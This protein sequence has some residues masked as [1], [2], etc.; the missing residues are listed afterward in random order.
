[1]RR[2]GLLLALVPA[3]ILLAPDMALA[4]RYSDN[5]LNLVTVILAAVGIAIFFIYCFYEHGFH[6]GRKKTEVRY[7]SILRSEKEKIRYEHSMEKQMIIAEMDGQRKALA[8]EM[9]RQHK[10]LAEKEASLEERRDT[11]EKIVAEKE[12]G[13]PWLAGKLAEFYTA[14]DEATAEWSETKNIPAYKAADE[15]K[16][17]ASE[18]RALLKKLRVY[19]YQLEYYESLFPW[20]LEYRDIDIPEKEIIRREAGS[21]AETGEDPAF[22]FL[23]DPAGQTALTQTELFQRALEG[24]VARRRSPWEIGR[25]Y[26]RYIGYKMEMD[27]FDVKY[28]GALQGKKDMGVDLIATKNRRVE[29]IQCKYWAQEKT[30]HEK[31]IF[32]L[33]GSALMYAYKN[34]GGLMNAGWALTDLTNGNVTPV[35]V[36]SCGVSDLARSMAK[37]LR[38]TIRDNQPFD[39]DY[40][41]IKCNI[42]RHDKKKIFH[43]PF[44]Q[45]YDSIKIEP[46]ENEFYAR[47]VDEA[48]KKGFRRAFRRRDGKG[49]G[50][51]PLVNQ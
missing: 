50:Q 25:D 33:F 14:R 4:A 36:C 42:S 23:E 44:D 37:D 6:K 45:M 43:L 5:D 29:I 38:V 27:G 48:E 3:I 35:L 41:R 10:A 21:E 22:Q 9:D 46:G 39:P 51:I 18:K 32:Q 30:I 47:T 7:D 11:F 8:A 26:E 24:Y 1:M 31:H 13:F 28:L 2:T 12:I 34:G 19:Q 16:R 40:P 49:A 17:I 15:V 20:L